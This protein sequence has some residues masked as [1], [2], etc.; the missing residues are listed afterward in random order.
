MERKN[1]NFERQLINPGRR[2][3]KMSLCVLSKKLPLEEEKNKRDCSTKFTVSD[4]KK[5]KR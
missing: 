2:E 4:R 3:L 1:K 5:K